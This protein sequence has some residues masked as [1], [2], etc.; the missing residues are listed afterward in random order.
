[1]VE[2]KDAR[3]IIKDVLRM[4]G[5]WKYIVPFSIYIFAGD[6][7]RFVFTGYEQYHVYIG[8]TL[9]TFIV[10]IILLGSRHRF[11]E[12]SKKY[13]SFDVLTIFIGMLIFI[14]WVGLEG[15]YPQFFSASAHYDTTTFGGTL[16]MV[17]ILVRFIGSV[18]VAPVIEELFMRSFL[19]RYIISPKWED[20]SI[21]SYTFESFAIVALVFG[22]SHYRWLPGLLT[23]ILLNLLLYRKSNIVSCIVAHGIAN[24]LLLL[25]VV[26]TGSWFYY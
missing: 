13:L 9:R 3:L 19:M 26:A 11:P 14:L 16:I 5:A 22:F 21:G 17:L 4:E 6:I 25:Y 10:G 7:A 8:Y 24:L 20:V 18:L 1:V 23:A 2:K 12:L 15:F